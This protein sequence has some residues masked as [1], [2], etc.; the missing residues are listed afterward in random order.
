MAQQAGRSSA[1]RAASPST[2]STRPFSSFR[3]KPPAAP[4]SLPPSPLALRWGA[5]TDSRLVPQSACRRRQLYETERRH[6]WSSDIAGE[7]REHSSRPASANSPT[8]PTQLFCSLDALADAPV[9]R[10][11]SAAAAEVEAEMRSRSATATRRHELRMA[12]AV[13]SREW[14]RECEHAALQKAR[15]VANEFAGPTAVAPP[16]RPASSTT[17]GS[18]VESTADVA[19]QLLVQ[20]IRELEERIHSP[21]PESRGGHAAELSLA[22]AAAAAQARPTPPPLSRP[23]LAS[24]TASTAYGSAAVTCMNEALLNELLA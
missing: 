1:G 23:H 7:A 19:E 3:E 8:L 16:P 4:F 18:K 11:G 15:S 22:A 6:L 20:T 5:S 10:A 17:S 14:G 24:P 12:D 21:P 13:L 2:P 9:V